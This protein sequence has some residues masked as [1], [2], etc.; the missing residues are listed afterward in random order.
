MESWSKSTRRIGA[1]R[2]EVLTAYPELRL[3][4]I[5]HLDHGSLLLK[6]GLR[7]FV[8]L[9]SGML[10]KIELANPEAVYPVRAPLVLPPPAGQPGAPFRDPNLKLAVLSE[11]VE[12]AE[13]DLGEPKDFLTAL[14]DHPVDLERKGHEKID[15]AYDYLVRYPLSQALLDKVTELVLDG[16][17]DIYPYIWYFWDGESDDFDIRSFEGIETLRNLKKM[18]LISMV[19][20]GK[21][22]LTPLQSIPGLEYR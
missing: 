14:L 10:R 9:N 17:N 15:A 20:K 12:R 6:P 7:L 4:S 1:S 5:R 8:E 18:R 16:G 3:G 19:D 21:A 2:A 22:D 13:I 11:L